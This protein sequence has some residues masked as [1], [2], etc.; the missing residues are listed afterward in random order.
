MAE[1]SK[2]TTGRVCPGQVIGV[3]LKLLLLLLAVVAAVAGEEAAEPLVLTLLALLVTFLDIFGSVAR[4]D[5]PEKD[6]I[7]QFGQEKRERQTGR[8]RLPLRNVYQKRFET[9]AISV[10]L[11]Y[12]RRSEGQQNGQA[13]DFQTPKC[14]FNRL[15]CPRRRNART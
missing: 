6:A 8:I 10:K 11:I 2:N 9:R 13:T 7:M 12:M 1:K 5:S 14:R 15:D 4:G 3:C